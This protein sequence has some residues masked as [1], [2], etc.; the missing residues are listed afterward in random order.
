[1]DDLTGNN[2]IE[3]VTVKKTLDDLFKIKNRRPLKFFLGLELA[4]NS[5]G[6]S[7]CQRS[8]HLTYCKM[9]VC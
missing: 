8:T 9:L 4:R 3:V 5:K 1:M 2:T 6:I 7:L